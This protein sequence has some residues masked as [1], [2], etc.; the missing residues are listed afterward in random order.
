MRVT[1]PLFTDI[2]VDGPEHA[3]HGLGH[4]SEEFLTI[5]DRFLHP[6]ALQYDLLNSSKIKGQQQR[7][8]QADP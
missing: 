5:H 4:L 8:Q 7:E 2:P 1:P 3:I 6:F